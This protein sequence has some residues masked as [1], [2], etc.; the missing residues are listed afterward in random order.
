MPSILFIC[1]GN[2]FRS[3]VAEYALKVWLGPDSDYVVGSAGIEAIPQPVH[4]LV[5]SCLLKKGANP[6]PH[7]P[8]KLT[9]DLLHRADIPVVMSL[10]H[11]EFIRQ[12]FH[13]EVLLFNQICYQREEPILDLGEAIPEW[14]V[15]LEAA[16]E[17]VVSIIDYI[18]DAMPAFVARIPRV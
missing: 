3:M 13:Q 10:N 14:S 6:S 4:S 15:N 2:V 16:H 12:H 9:R 5:R 7:V 17:Y 18:W 8:R 1:T 11:R